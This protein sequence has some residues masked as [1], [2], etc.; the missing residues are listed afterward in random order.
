MHAPQPD[1]QQTRTL[2]GAALS[3]AKRKRAEQDAM[4]VGVSALGPV[5]WEE[6]DAEEEQQAAATAGGT[7]HISAASTM[8]TDCQSTL[9]CYV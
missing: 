1:A 6:S 7:M 5:G 8:A 9:G 2:D 3:G 4:P